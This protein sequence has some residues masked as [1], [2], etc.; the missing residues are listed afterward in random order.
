[1]ADEL[2]HAAVILSDCSC[3]VAEFVVRLK[4]NG[5]SIIGSKSGRRATRANLEDALN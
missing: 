5:S 1:M 4:V 2:L 3:A